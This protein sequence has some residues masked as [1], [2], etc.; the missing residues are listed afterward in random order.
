MN[1]IENDDATGEGGEIG[2]SGSSKPA[3]FNPKNDLFPELLPPV[4][5]ARWPTPGSRA[6]DALQALLVGPV[7]QCD[8]WKSWRL[9]ASIKQLQYD[10]WD[11]VKRDIPKPG[12]R[13]P[14]REYALDRAAPGTAAALQSRHRG[15][16]TAEF[17]TVL[18]AI[19]SL[20]SVA[21]WM[22]GGPA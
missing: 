12:C 9:S 10:G 20:L 7:N 22:I 1:T 16:V 18:W 14:V 3:H 13:S 2:K 19:A 6:D 4:F 15:F 5:A 11:F 17:I 21:V 8:Y